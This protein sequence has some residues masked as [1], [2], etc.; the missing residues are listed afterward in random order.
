MEHPQFE[1][2]LDQLAPTM[3][4]RARLTYADGLERGLDYEGL[5]DELYLYCCLKSRGQAIDI[6]D[7]LEAEN[8]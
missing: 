7:E 4:R 3:R 5:R 6:L 2:E 1:R 8:R